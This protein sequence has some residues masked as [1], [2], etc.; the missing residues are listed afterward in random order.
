MTLTERDHFHGE[1]SPLTASLVAL[2]AIVMMGCGNGSARPSGA[3]FEPLGAPTSIESTGAEG[4][5][6][7]GRTVVGWGGPVPFRGV[8]ST[9][10][11][12][13]DESGEVIEL[14]VPGRAKQSSSDGTIIAGDRLY[15][16]V[17]RFLPILTRAFRWSASLGP[18]SLVPDEGYPIAFSV[19][20]MSADGSTIVGPALEP[21]QIEAYRWDLDSGLSLLPRL[22]RDAN[23]VPSAITPDAS[24]VIGYLN[25]CGT[26]SPDR[27]STGIRWD[28]AGSITILPAVA[29]LCECMTTDVSRDGKGVVGTCDD[30]SPNTYDAPSAVR[31]YEEVGEILPMV[32]DE[33]G[34]F[35]FATS[36]D[37]SVVV[38]TAFVN[39]ARYAFVWNASAG[40]RLLADLLSD[41]G[42]DIPSGWVLAEGVDVSDDGRVVVGTALLPDGRTTAFRATIPQRVQ[43]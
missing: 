17:D 16:V 8:P 6:A 35:A 7:D 20:A 27:E 18:Q 41:A 39:D 26:A 42:V 13:W 32:D 43:P 28:R 29:G 12:I 37:A 11:L 9:V 14:G 21:R 40:K 31:W 15:Q 10:A 3:K 30:Q 34:S 24:S 33:R 5:S 38:G 22:D 23:H 1:R 4:V 36:A 25:A 2:A 19:S